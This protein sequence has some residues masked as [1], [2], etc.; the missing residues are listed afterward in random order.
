MSD[1]S[2]LVMRPAVREGALDS[3]CVLRRLSPKDA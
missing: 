1:E 2:K 3:L